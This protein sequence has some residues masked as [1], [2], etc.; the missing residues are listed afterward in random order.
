M[1]TKL[2]L[3]NINF[4]FLSETEHAAPKSRNNFF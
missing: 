3:D 2:N 1:T 4:D